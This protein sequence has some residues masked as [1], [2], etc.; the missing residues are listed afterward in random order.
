MKESEVDS[1]GLELAGGRRP[2]GRAEI[3]GWNEIGQGIRVLDS[4]S[5]GGQI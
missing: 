3:Y 1:D 2:A 4:L 5:G